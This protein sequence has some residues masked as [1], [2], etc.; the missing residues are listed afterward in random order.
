MIEVYCD[1]FPKFSNDLSKSF[2]EVPNQTLLHGDF[3]NG[4]HMYLEQDGVVKVVAFDFQ[5]VGQGLAVSDIIKFFNVA[6]FHSSIPEDLDLLKKYH[7]SLLLSGAE[8]YEYEDFKKHFVLGC[9]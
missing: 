8:Y 2:L 9:F 4:N 7:E 3:H 6:K 1:R 5:M